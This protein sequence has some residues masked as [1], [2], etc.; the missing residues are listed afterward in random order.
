AAATAERSGVAITTDID[1]PRRNA[2]DPMVF[3]VVRELLANV[4]R[5]SEASHASVKLNVDDG[6]CRLDVA[7]DGIGITADAMMRRL[8]EGHIGLASQRARV[9][10]AGGTL[11]ILDVPTGAHICVQWPL[12]R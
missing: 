1:C 6:T 5:H 2:I 8:A 12:P 9:E 7:D 11:K 4:V 10:A 3:G